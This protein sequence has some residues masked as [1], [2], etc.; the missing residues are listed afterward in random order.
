MITLGNERAHPVP[1]G[2]AAADRVDTLAVVRSKVAKTGS[3][4]GKSLPR[5]R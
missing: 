5:A 2:R 3:E 4:R 1:A